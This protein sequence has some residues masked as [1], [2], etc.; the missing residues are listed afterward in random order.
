MICPECK[1]EETL[2][3]YMGLQFGKY[4]CK[5]CNYLGP[6]SLESKKQRSAHHLEL[7]RE[8]NQRFFDRWAKSYD[9]FILGWW[10]RYIQREVIR[11]LD[12]TKNSSVLD[13]GCGTGYTIS[14]LRRT[15]S[16]GKLAGIDL[17]PNMIAQA[18][19]KLSGTENVDFRQ[20]EV[21][22]IPFKKNS[23]DGVICTE[24]FHHFPEPGK[25]L[26]EMK[27]VLKNQGKIIIADISFL[28]HFLFNILF[29]L[30]PGFVKMYS[31]GEISQWAEKVGLLVVKQKRAGIVALIHVLQKKVAAPKTPKLKLGL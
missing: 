19:K 26:Q 16:S 1:K 2:Q 13:V 24:A 9:R 21:E 22:K 4:K 6:I 25:A 29:M 30:E 27:R 18:Q 11:Q 28:P 12:L 31:K 10:M 3:P 5:N 20:A 8:Q 14:E 15:I 7:K 23:F 17:S